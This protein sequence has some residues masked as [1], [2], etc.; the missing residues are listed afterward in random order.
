MKNSLFS[1]KEFPDG[2]KKYG[3]LEVGRKRK[4]R[5]LGMGHYRKSESFN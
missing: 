2:M 5:S 3:R 4:K 1:I